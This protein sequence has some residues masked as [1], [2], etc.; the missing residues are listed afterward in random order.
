MK[1]RKL[2]LEDATRMLE[3][4]H[5]DDVVQNMGTNF[6][7]KKLEDCKKFINNCIKDRTNYHLAIVDDND[8]YMG[9][10]SLKHIDENHSCAEFAITVH[11]DA[12]GKGYSIFGMKE[13]IKI[14]FEQL[15]LKEIYWYVSKKNIRAIKFY[16]KNGFSRSIP[17]KYSNVTECEMKNMYWYLVDSSN[18]NTL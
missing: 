7:E 13:I 17:Y 14:G 10:V 9:T 3:W 8:L 4:M 6:K 5:D 11:R 18:E 1:L 12:M 15:D 16:D 2:K